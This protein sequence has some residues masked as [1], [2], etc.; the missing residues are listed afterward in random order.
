[1]G[2]EEPIARIR[3]IGVPPASQVQIRQTRSECPVE[4]FSDTN[5][6]IYAFS[7]GDRRQNIALDL[8]LARRNDRRSNF[9]QVIDS[10]ISRSAIRSGRAISA[11]Q[12]IALFLRFFPNQTQPTK[13]DCL[14]HVCLQWRNY[15]WPS[16]LHIAGHVLHNYGDGIRFAIRHR[17]DLVVCDLRH[18]VRPGPCSNGTE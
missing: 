9:G 17:E 15:L 3:R 18:S 11:G 2:R 7:T 5:V 8:P 1:M 13:S 16:R 10:L 12:A 6:L 4:A 14:R